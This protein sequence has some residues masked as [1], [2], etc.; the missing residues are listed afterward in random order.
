[1]RRKRRLAVFETIVQAAAR[2]PPVQ[3]ALQ[4]IARVG[5]LDHD[6]TYHSAASTAFASKP[7]ASHSGRG[8][9]RRL[10][11]IFGSVGE[12]ASISSRKISGLA[13]CSPTGD[14]I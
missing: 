3:P 11:S 1:M 14:P 10:S 8:G 9:P 6:A 4:E 2:I 7:H 12:Y 5:T 13:E